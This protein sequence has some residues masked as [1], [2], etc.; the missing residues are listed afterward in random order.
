MK[1]KTRRITILT[2]TLTLLL[3]ICGW[4]ALQIIP[5]ASKPF[6]AERKISDIPTP[7]G[8]SRVA[9][10]EGSMGEWLRNLPLRKAGTPVYLYTGGLAR[11]QWLSYAV[12]DLPLLSNNEQCADAC[13]RLRAEYLY[14]QGRYLK[15]NFQTVKR[16]PMPYL[17]GASRKAFEKY[18]RDVY[19]LCN[20][21][22]L[23]RSLD[24]RPLSEVQPGDVL[25]YPARKGR[26]Y[27][28]AVMVVDV[29]KNKKGEIMIM[30]AEGNTPARDLHIVRNAGGA[31]KK[32]NLKGDQHVGPFRFEPDNLKQW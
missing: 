9:C 3:G 7:R 12:L 2:I 30:C 29:A 17:G 6:S 25:V 8:Y 10:E 26:K 23:Y 20:T 11:M 16:S 4:A 28:H 31:W 22:S 15:I 27:G 18:M 19:G 21:A 1:K 14:S 32:L 24:Q 5:P 13:M